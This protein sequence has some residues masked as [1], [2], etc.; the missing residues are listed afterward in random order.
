MKL[1]MLCFFLLMGLTDRLGF[2]GEDILMNVIEKNEDYAM[3]MNERNEGLNGG[4]RRQ[5]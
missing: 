2:L 4:G 3:T 1:S 5:E